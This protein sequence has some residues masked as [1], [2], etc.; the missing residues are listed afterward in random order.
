MSLTEGEHLLT[1]RIDQDWVDFDWI[2]FVDANSTGV[3]NVAD[4]RIEIVPNPAIASAMVVA[5]GD[6]QHVEVVNMLGKSV[7]STTSATIDVSSLTAGVYLVKAT[8]NG[9]VVVKRL[10]VVK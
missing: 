8:V 3:E 9:V 2:R 5:N 4:N 7:L 10:V 6:V 1:L